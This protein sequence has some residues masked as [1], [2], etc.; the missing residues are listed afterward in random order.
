MEEILMKH[1][2]ISQNEN[3]WIKGDWII[4]FDKDSVEIFNDPDKAPG[5]YYIGPIDKIDINDFL[6]E[7]D[8]YL[9]KE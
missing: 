4:R 7:I 6:K 5:K 1:G 8:N 2:Y 9:M 3:E